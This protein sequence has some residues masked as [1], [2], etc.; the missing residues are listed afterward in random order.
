MQKGP[1]DPSSH[2]QLDKEDQFLA[3][4]REIVFN[5]PTDDQVDV[6]WLGEQDGA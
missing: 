2:L 3:W 1:V 5:H 6:D 4:L